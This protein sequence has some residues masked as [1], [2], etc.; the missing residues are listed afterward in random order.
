VISTTRSLASLLLATTCF[1]TSAAAAQD[2][3]PLGEFSALR[4]IPAPGNHNFLMTDGA[5]VDGHLVPW[6]GLLLD[7]AHRPFVLYDASCAADD[8]TN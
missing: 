1:F 3:V 2:D 8:D 7:Y 5:R 4:F 6:A